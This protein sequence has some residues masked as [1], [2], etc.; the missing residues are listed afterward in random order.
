M[1]ISDDM[2]DKKNNRK[3]GILAGILCGIM[4]GFLVVINVDAAYI[5]FAVFI[6]TFFAKKINCIN[7]IVT[8]LIFLAIISILGF[9]AIGLGTLLICTLAAY[10][11]EIGNDNK[12]IY[13]K[14]RFL[15]LFFEYRFALK[16]TIFVLAICG[17]ISSFY[18]SFILYGIHFMAVQTFLLFLTFELA[19]EI[20][21]IKFDSI[22]ERFFS[23]YK[24][25][26]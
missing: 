19:Y 18:P 15:E 16:T 4:L 1:K 3:L 7:H 5:F 25:P 13:K 6:G 26:E 12:N 11:D 17:V 8:A 24:N 14:S 9:P 20:A 21:G 23:K 10:I 22:Y 2:H